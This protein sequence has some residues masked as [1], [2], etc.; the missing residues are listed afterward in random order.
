MGL[1]FFFFVCVYMCMCVFLFLF[2]RTFFPF[3]LQETLSAKSF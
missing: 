2:R 1:S 3:S